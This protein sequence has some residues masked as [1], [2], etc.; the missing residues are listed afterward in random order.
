MIHHEEL[1]RVYVAAGQRELARK[2]W[3]TVLTLPA[4]TPQEQQAQREAKA[5]LGL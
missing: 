4:Q 5:S 3:Q 2:E 1:A